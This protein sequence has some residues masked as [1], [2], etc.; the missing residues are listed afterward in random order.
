MT[1]QSARLARDADGTPYSERYGDVYASRDGAVGQARHVF[2]GGV[3]LPEA[4][5]GRDPI[6]RYRTYLLGSGV[7]DHAFVR[8]CDEEAAAWVAEIRAAVT[9]LGEPPASEM[10][11]HA[12]ADPPATLRR[13]RRELL[14]DG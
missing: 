2:L 12:Y 9:A 3:G 10:F 1:L 8:A 11:D 7:I 6:D 5:R 13:Q 4:W 14:G